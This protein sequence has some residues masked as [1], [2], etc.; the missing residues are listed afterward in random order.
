MPLATRSSTHEAESSVSDGRRWIFCNRL[1]R[2]CLPLGLAHLPS[3]EFL[4]LAAMSLEFLRSAVNDG[5]MCE[6][7]LKLR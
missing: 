2:P 7:P 1:N 5:C 6:G 3:R 4:L